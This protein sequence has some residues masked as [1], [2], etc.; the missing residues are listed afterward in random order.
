MNVA[1]SKI[2]VQKAIGSNEIPNWLLKTNPESL[3]ALISSIFNASVS[4]STVLALWKSAD[5]VSFPKTKSSQLT[6]QDLRPISLA[7]SFSQILESSVFNWSFEHISLNIDPNQ[8]GNVKTSFTSHPLV[9]LIHNWL[10]SSDTLDIVIRACMIDFSKDFDHNIVIKKLQSLNVHP[11]LF[12]WCT[13]FVRC[14]YLRVKVGL[15]KS[16]WVLIHADVPQGT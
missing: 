1:L 16:S 11:F 15:T 6:D 10:L 13:D 14:R 3:S 9:N 5:I 2:K 4:Q 12:N 7:P 8:H